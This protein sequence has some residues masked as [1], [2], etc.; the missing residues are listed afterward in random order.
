MFTVEE[1]KIGGGSK[2]Q[3]AGVSEKVTISEVKLIVNDTYKTNNL[4]FVTINEHEQQGLSKKMSLKTEVSPGKKVAAWTVTA[5]N[6]LNILMAVGKTEEEARAV[7]TA[8]DVNELVKRLTSNLIGKPFRGLFASREY[9]PGK[10]AIELYS[11]EPV[12]GTK[13]VYDISNPN[14]NFKLPKADNFYE[15]NSANVGSDALPF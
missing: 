9:E 15:S 4:Q 12:G 7:L 13:L 8:P 3:S 2:Y 14:H 11:A 5:K 1:V 6:L 10:N